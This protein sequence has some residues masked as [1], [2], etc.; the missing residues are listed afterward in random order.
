MK[1]Y[2]NITEIR[3]K[4]TL[5]RRLSLSGLGVLF[6]GLL[7]SFIPTWLPP[8]QPATGS[9]NLFLQQN[10]T[11][12]SFA[13]L[14][15]GFILASVG[16]YYINRFARRRWPGAKTSS[17]ARPDELLERNMKGFDDKYAYFA[18]SL[19]A[20]YVVAGPCGVLVFAVR[21]DRS[22]INV[23]GD[24]WKEPFSLMRF[25]T[26]FAREG[27][28]DPTREIQDQTSKVRSLL[29]ENGTTE[30]A[31]ANGESLASVPIEGA[32]VFLHPQAVL[33][34]ENANPP[35]LRADQVKE[36][37]RRRAKEAKVQP[38]T[39]RRLTERLAQAAVYQVEAEEPA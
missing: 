28:G 26:L 12:I 29:T 18:H 3:R 27:L 24:N 4:E 36:Y 15:I 31:G 6:V 17:I 7:A 10:W 25:L 39:V 1:S 33:N 21:S 37:I 20:P 2:R 22:R 16:S 35:A 34:A 38:D 8:D 30:G 14:P 19:P 9:F 13:A 32:V 5:G 23:Q 11:W